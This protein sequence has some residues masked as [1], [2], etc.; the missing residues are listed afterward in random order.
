MQCVLET[1]IILEQNAEHKGNNV[2][3]YWNVQFA[4]RVC[5]KCGQKFSEFQRP[6]APK[7]PEEKSYG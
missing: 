2:V 1:G 4:K 3:M 6:Y 5:L 7:A